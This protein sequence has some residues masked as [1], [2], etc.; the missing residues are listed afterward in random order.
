[1]I[2]C[3][4]IGVRPDER[5]RKA[6][7]RDELIRAVTGRRDA[8]FRADA[9]RAALVLTQAFTRL[10]DGADQPSYSDTPTKR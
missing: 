4:S 2:N 3:C 7:N 10:S 9:E 5:D 8:L 1:M 6:G